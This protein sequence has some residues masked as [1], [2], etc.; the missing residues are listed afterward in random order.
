MILAIYSLMI[1]RGRME[2]HILEVMTLFADKPHVRIEDLVHKAVEMLPPP[3]E[4]KRD[5][6]R[7]SIVRALQTLSRE[8]D[9]PLKVEGN[10]VFFFE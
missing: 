8:K 9:G 10:L 6:R 5:I 3:E 4:G 7:Q 2:N 1:H